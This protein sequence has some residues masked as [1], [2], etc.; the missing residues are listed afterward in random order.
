MPTATLTSKGQVTIPAS[1][2]K[3]LRLR[4]GDKVVFSLHGEHEVVLRPVTRGVDEVFGCLGR[5]AKGRRASPEAMDEGI[6]RRMR[7]GR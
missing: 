3:K 4:A 7:E 6:R 1:V 2:R 5:A